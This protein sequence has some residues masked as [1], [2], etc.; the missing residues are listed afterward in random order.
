MTSNFGGLETYLLQQF[1]NIDKNKI[2]YD[3]VNNNCE[4]KII[5]EIEILKTGSKIYNIPTRRLN[6]LKHY[7]MWMILLKNHRSE[8]KAIVL[9]GLSLAYVF[10]LFIA[11]IFGIPIRIIHSHN[12]GY[13]SEPGILRKVLVV[14]NKILLSFSATDYWACSKKAGEWMFGKNRKFTIIHNAIDSKRYKFNLEKRDNVKKVLNIENKFVVGNVGRFA[15]QKNHE[16]LINVFYE[17]QKIEPES[18]LMLVGGSVNTD[19]F[20]IKAKEQVKNLNIQNKVLFLGMRNDVPDLM[21]SMDCFILPSHFEGLPLVVIEA[22][23]IGLKSYLSDVIADE[24]K[25]T[26]IVDFISLKESPEYWAKQILLNRNYIRKD[27]TDEIKKAGYDIKTE[28][29]RIEQFYLK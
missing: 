13:E 19:E 6:P 4:K 11:K 18:V 23:C 22:Q 14:F 9:N 29:K 2:I 28:I 24:V 5:K 16:F 12:S 20:L 8:Y 7:L 26:D 10:P 27:M 17:L 25:I 21:Q 1:E 3:F 15:Y